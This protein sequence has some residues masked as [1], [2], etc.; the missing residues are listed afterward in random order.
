MLIRLPAGRPSSF[1]L[2]VTNKAERDLKNVRIAFG[3]DTDA[4]SRIAVLATYLAKED[5]PVAPQD[6]SSIRI[7]V[8]RL[9][10]AA[11]RYRYTLYASVNGEIADWIKHAGTFDVEPGDFFGNGRLPPHGQGELLIEH[12]FQLGTRETV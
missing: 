3:I 4:G 9:P 2:L 7:D 10:L 8:P 5:F 11:G 1:V 12:N 6:T